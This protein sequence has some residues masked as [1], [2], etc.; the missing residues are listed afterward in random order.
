MMNVVPLP[1]ITHPTVHHLLRMRRTTMLLVLT[2]APLLH[3]KALPMVLL[4]RDTSQA[5]LRDLM[6]V[7]MPILMSL[8]AIRLTRRNLLA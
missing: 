4:H 5:P 1:L 8:N 3:R 7:L 2:V 6:V